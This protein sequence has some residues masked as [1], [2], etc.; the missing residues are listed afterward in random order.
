M[1]GKCL[2]L[3]GILTGGVRRSSFSGIIAGRIR[4]ATSSPWHA[5]VIGSYFGNTTLPET[6][7][8]QDKG[9]FSFAKYALYRDSGSNFSLG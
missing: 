8:A 7:R 6:V 4:G 5:A 9:G 1:L 2:S 3:D